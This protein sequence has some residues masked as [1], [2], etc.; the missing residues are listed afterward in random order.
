MCVHVHASVPPRNKFRRKI[1]KRASDKRIMVFIYDS[2]P[3]AGTFLC[4]HVRK[5]PRGIIQCQSNNSRACGTRRVIN[6]GEI[7]F[8]RLFHKTTQRSNVKCTHM[9]LL[10][11]LARERE[12]VEIT[13]EHQD[14]FT[15]RVKFS[16]MQIAIRW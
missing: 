13:S 10:L 15:L 8:I 9:R 1:D 7:A 4:E 14:C 11:F 2:L 5:M 12:R 6:V 16:S 3:S